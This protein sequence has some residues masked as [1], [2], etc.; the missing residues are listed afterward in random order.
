MS[1]YIFIPKGKKWGLG[2]GRFYF[3]VVP[4]PELNRTIFNFFT[5]VV[6]TTLQR[7]CKLPRKLHWYAIISTPNIWIV[8]KIAS[9]DSHSQGLVTDACLEAIEILGVEIIACQ[10]GVEWVVNWTFTT[11]DRN[12]RTPKCFCKIFWWSEE[13]YFRYPVLEKREPK[14]IEELRLKKTKGPHLKFK[15]EHGGEVRRRQRLIQRCHGTTVHFSVGIDGES[16]LPVIFRGLFDVWRT[17]KSDTFV[18]NYQHPVSLL[19][20]E[21]LTKL[22]A[23]RIRCVSLRRTHPHMYPSRCAPLDV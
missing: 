11:H 14:K 13:L 4:A 18:T 5:R 9:L 19:S 3:L 6:L 15:N 2:V 20:A 10:Y 16:C 1:V 17:I 7:C 12:T 8:T 21:G 22:F 23:V